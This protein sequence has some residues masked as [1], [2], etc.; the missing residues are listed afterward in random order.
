MDTRFYKRL[1]EYCRAR[2][3]SGIG[4]GMPELLASCL[5]HILGGFMVSGGLSEDSDLKKEIDASVQLIVR[6]FERA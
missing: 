2:A 6:G 3:P 5:V 4:R 1:A